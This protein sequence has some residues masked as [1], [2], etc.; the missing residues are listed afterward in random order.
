MA[1]DGEK[2]TV[3]CEMSVIQVLGP[4]YYDS[5]IVAVAS[6]KHLL[7]SYVLPMLPSLLSDTI[8]QQDGAPPHY[9]LEMHQL[10]DEKLP[11]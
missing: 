10:L 11:N 4:Y 9:S 6:C 5:A 7:I 1:R 8:L 3:W 2:V